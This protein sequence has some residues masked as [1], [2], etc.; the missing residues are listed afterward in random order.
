MDECER[1]SEILSIIGEIAERAESG[2]AILVEGRR[3]RDSLLAL[4]VRGDIIMT[5]HQQLFRLAEELAREK[6]DVVILTDWDERGEEVALK[7]KEYLKA[8][9]VYADC[10]LRDGLKDL[11]KK[12]IKDIESLYKLVERLKKECS[13]PQHY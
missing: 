2:S 7:I 4:G 12:E 13:K 10:S 8:D 3:D 1:L 5:S 11:V 6:P 9:G